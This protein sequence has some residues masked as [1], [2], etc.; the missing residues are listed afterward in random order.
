MGFLHNVAHSLPPSLRHPSERESTPRH[1]P[2]YTNH[3]GVYV[4]SGSRP[5]SCKMNKEEK[6]RDFTKWLVENDIPTVE[7][8]VAILGITVEPGNIR[9]HEESLSEEVKLQKINGMTRRVVRYGEV[10]PYGMYFIWTKLSAIYLPSLVHAFLSP[11]L[12][13]DL[14]DVAF[15]EFHSPYCAVL[16]KLVNSEYYAKYMVSEDPSASPGKR[17]GHVQAN[18]IARDADLLDIG[19]RLP[20]DTKRAHFEDTVYEMVQL[21]SACIV[22]QAED[23][24]FVPIN[25]TVSS[26][27]IPYLDRWATQL[28][29]EKGGHVC[30]LVAAR[31][32]RSEQQ[33]TRAARVARNLKSLPPVREYCALEACKSTYTLS[34]CGRCR[35]TYYCSKVHQEQDWGK[36][37]HA[38]YST[39]Y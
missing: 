31:F 17:I 28:P 33:W 25:E 10:D 23:P 20:D 24:A 22:F 2:A 1:L 11:P 27:L 35:I 38:C 18:R 3:E 8:F 29:P 30:E 34:I 9:V 14:S 21:L 39:V 6:D 5:C 4:E 16:C 12:P 15:Y 26:K 37:T 13:S 19:L 36:H 32:R 7:E